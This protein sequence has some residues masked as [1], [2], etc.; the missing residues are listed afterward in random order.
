MNDWRPE[1]VWHCTEFDAD[2]NEIRSRTITDAQMKAEDEANG[3]I[4]YESLLGGALTIKG[5]AV[6]FEA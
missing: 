2:F 5:P 4:E 1:K 6:R 3:I